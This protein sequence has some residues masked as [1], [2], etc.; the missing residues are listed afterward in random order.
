MSRNI[1]IKRQVGQ[2]A[3]NKIYTETSS[4]TVAA[5]RMGRTGIWSRFQIVEKYEAANVAVQPEI[6]AR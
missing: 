3:T 4:F 1:T 6:Q 5:L 2:L